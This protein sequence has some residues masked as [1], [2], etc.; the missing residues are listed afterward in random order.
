MFSLPYGGIQVAHSTKHF[1]TMRGSDPPT[2]MPD[3][4]VVTTAADYVAGRDPVL[5][6]VIRRE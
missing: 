3:R 6:A 2:L 5:E 4:V 1:V